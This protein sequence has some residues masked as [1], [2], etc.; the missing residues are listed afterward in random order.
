VQFLPEDHTAFIYQFEGALM[1]GDQLL[2]EQ[3][4]AVL[5]EG[6]QV[7]IS[8]DNDSARFLLVSGGAIG[9]PIVQ[10]GPF[11]MNTREQIEQAL[12]DYRDGKLVQTRAN[13]V[14]AD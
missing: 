3:Q 6:E 5:G 7:T 11:V 4:L 9:E 8:T 14:S 2:E 13:M 1:V 10:Y 12:A